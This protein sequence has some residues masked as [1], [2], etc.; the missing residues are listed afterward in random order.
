M[1]GIGNRRLL[2]RRDFLA[3]LA[4]AALLGVAGCASE[5]SEG[6][7]RIVFSHGEDSEILRDQIRRFN[8]HN[9]GTIEV[10]LR[11]A[12]AD[13]SQYFEKLRIE[14]QA[15]QADS[16]VISGDVIWPAQFAANGWISDLFTADLREPYLPAAI[17][18]NT[19]EGAV[20]GVP[21]FTDAGMLYYRKDLL[22]QAGFSE[23][24]KTWAEM[25]EMVEKVRRETGTRYVFVFQG[26]DYEGG[27][28]NSLE[29]IWS[30]G[31][32][33][34]DP[35]DPDDV[36]VAAPEA[37][38]GLETAR[39]MVADGVAPGAVPSFKEYES[40]TVFLNGDALFMRNWPYVYARAADSSL[41]RVE[42]G[43]IGVAT[44]PVARP[45]STSHSGLGGW[46]L[47]INAASEKTEAAWAFIRYLSAPEQQKERALRGGYLP[48]REDCYEDREILSE[49]PV[50]TL[51]RDAIRNVRSRPVSPLYRDMSLAMAE[52]FHASLSGTVATERAAA[53]LEEDLE[54]I[55][56]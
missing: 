20:Y 45:G 39:G 38:A 42:Q 12:P 5:E 26:A 27:V 7:A 35:H 48:T 3:G 54:R 24:P 46:N 1:K 56:R 52:R 10:A 36:T 53:L 4:G 9:R 44:L 14:F 25:Q 28:V 15:G 55:L 6:L 50:I 47:M 41:S 49:V 16:D 33:V 8:E 2:S 34:L 43:R 32:N 21:W 13:S 22:E 40:Y 17:D 31:G 30:S 23:P 29:F 51:G 37:V 18:S 11:L 19:Y